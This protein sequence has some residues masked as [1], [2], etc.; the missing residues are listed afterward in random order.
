MSKNRISFQQ[1]LDYVEQL[2]I[3]QQESLIDIIRRRIIEL[4]RDELSISIMEARTEYK[5]GKIK[6]GSVNDL[7][8]D[9][10]K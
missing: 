5:K 9:L 3:E 10:E 6:A 4:R 8:K 2:P 7:T 1:L